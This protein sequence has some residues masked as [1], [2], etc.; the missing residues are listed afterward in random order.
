MNHAG[1]C[2]AE[3]GQR[4]VT[5]GRITKSRAVG[6]ASRGVLLP[7][8]KSIDHVVVAM[9]IT[10]LQIIEQAAPLADHLE[11]PAARVIIFDVSLEMGGQFVDPLS[12]QRDLTSG[13][14]V[15]VSCVLY[16]D[17]PCLSLFY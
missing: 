15:S 1:S 9:D 5:F 4:A 16:C 17:E 8:A 12:Q 13:D 7:D 10:A 14:P 6:A 11:Q 2:S 3:L